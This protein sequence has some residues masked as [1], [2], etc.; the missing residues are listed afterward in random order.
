MA[1]VDKTQVFTAEAIRV[2]TTVNSIVADTGAFTAE[3]IV[4]HNGL[5]Q[6]VTIQ[7]QGSIDATVWIDMGN[8]FNVSATSN[9]YA[10]VSDYF[11]CY[12]VTSISSTAPTTGTLDVWVLKAGAVN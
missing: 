5:N 8:S 1:T 7:L 10:T 6:T 2:D 11:P 9:D 12:R 3:T 4:V